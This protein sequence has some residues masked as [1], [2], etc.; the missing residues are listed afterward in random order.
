MTIR[1]TTEK[2]VT[3]Q[4]D[5]YTILLTNSAHAFSAKT[6]AA[7]GESA[8]TNVVALLGTEKVKASVTAADITAP[9]GVTCTVDSTTDPDSPKITIALASTVTVGGTVT[10]PVKVTGIDNSIL[11][12]DLI[13]SYTLA[14]TGA[15][16]ATGVG[17]NAV[18]T[19]YQIGTSATTPPT[20]TWS[21]SLVTP[22][23][24]SPYLWTRVVTT[25]TSGDPNTAYSVAK[26]GD[27]GAAGK[28]ISSAAI[29]Y[30]YGLSGSTVPTGTWSSTQPAAVAGE[31][32]WT[33]TILTYTDSSTSNPI[34]SVGH[35]GTD[36]SSALSIVLTSNN[37][38]V[39]KNGSGSTTYTAN[40]FLGS[41]LLSSTSTPTLESEGTLKWYVDGTLKATGTSTYTVE[42]ADFTDTEVVRV[43]LES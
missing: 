24:A 26:M 8:T 15:T 39:I 16:G 32:L 33:R 38:D 20:G 7:S 4:T 1:A 18:T 29:T 13:F 5:G 23:T 9:T 11:E 17:I 35:I 12:F 27:T 6:V 41:T 34:Y 31:Y 40:V 36:G 37:G 19:T 10:I 14:A 22:T 2:T 30:Q 21:S 43:Q 25:Y 3:D 28:G 42:A